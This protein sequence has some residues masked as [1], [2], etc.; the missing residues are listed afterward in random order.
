MQMLAGAALAGA[1]LAGLM[2]AWPVEAWAQGAQEKP[3]PSGDAPAAAPRSRLTLSGEFRSDAYRQEDFFLGA[4]AADTLGSGTYGDDNAFWTQRL[5]LR[6]R[7]ILSD[8]LNF[9]MSLDLAHGVWG[10]DN[11][12]PDRD[13][14]GFSNL[15]NNK[16][17]SFHLQAD[18]AFLSYRHRGTGT[19]WYL[20]R[21]QYGLG[22]LL[23]LDM[24]APGLQVYKDLDRWHTSVGGGYA[25]MSE[26]TDGLVD[27]DLWTGPGR[28]DSV[29]DGRDA[30][31]YYAEVRYQSPGR[32]LM[33]NPFLVYYI[34]RSNADGSTYLPNEQGFLDARFRPNISRARVLGLA[35]RAERGVFRLEAE[36]DLL[37]G[38]DR[39]NNL[40]SGA[41]E[42]LGRNNGDLTGTNIFGR[43]T[44]NQSRLTL[45]AAF[46]FGSGRELAF[47]HTSEGNFNSLRT[48]GNFYLTEV[49]E[50]GLALD[51]LGIVPEG[52]GSPFVRG[53]RGLENTL[54]FQVFGGFR[55]RN[56]LNVTGSYNIIRA[57]EPVRAWHDRNGDGVISPSGDEFGYEANDP[58]R[59]STATDLG[60]EIDARID[61]TLD[62]M[63]QLSLRGGIFSPGLAAGYLING[64]GAYQESAKEIRFGV[65]VPIPEFSLGG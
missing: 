61:W 8:D 10:I 1:W 28:P 40:N 30:D 43:L 63:V 48:Q 42:E 47:D 38:V 64:T 54:L 14:P 46:G 41:G 34:D 7:L 6:P 53:Y 44:M 45:G 55:L 2:V 24:D 50:D 62:G 25:K 19:R 23:V 5:T 12:P 51:E 56:N 16:S 27:A 11:Q 22:N 58:N 32:G 15:Y 59:V 4:R 20:G 39:V 33:L 52:L 57:N 37:Q 36:A 13:R 60:T 29:G 18:W 49:W 21:Q 17:N 31:L 3:A 26:G 35:A 65:R 9:N